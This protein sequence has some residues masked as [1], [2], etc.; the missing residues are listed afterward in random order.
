MFDD[1]EQFKFITLFED[2]TIAEVIEDIFLKQEA[3][4][5]GIE[6]INDEGERIY[7]FLIYYEN[8][9]S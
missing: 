3:V 9:E 7:P 6:I 2:T 4:P 1:I 8:F 5:V